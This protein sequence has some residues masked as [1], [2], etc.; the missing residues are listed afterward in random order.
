MKYTD[1]F[2]KFPIRLYDIVS[3]QETALAEEKHFEETKE[4]TTLPANFAVGYKSLRPNDIK[5][6]GDAY[7]NESNLELAMEEGFNICVVETF[8]G[9]VY[10]CNLKTEEFEGALNEHIIKFPASIALNT[11]NNSPTVLANS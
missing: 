10:E 2:F 5:A 7:S 6:F 3:L 11:N 8:Q 9:D 4:I 1:N